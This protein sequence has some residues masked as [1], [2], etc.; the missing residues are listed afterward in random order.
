MERFTRS[1]LL[2]FVLSVSLIYRTLTTPVATQHSAAFD[3][4]ARV[5][6][7]YGKN[8]FLLSSDVSICLPLRCS[9]KQ[10]RILRCSL[11]VQCPPRLGSFLLFAQGNFT[12]QIL[13]QTWRP[14]H[15]CIY[16]YSSLFLHEKSTQGK[17]PSCNS[18]DQDI[19]LLEKA[20][21]AF[22]VNRLLSVVQV[23]YIPF[24]I[25]TSTIVSTFLLNYSLRNALV[26]SFVG[27]LL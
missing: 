8:L 17:S 19:T 26:G 4:I 3:K 25:Y 24:S 13:G 27:D 6:Q 18:S 11:L 16:D 9:S 21:F 10:M 14:W 20:F 2:R 5:N 12:I 7:Q 1:S 22:H 15:V 23:Q